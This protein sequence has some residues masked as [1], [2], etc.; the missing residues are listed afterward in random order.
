V[1]DAWIRLF[2]SESVAGCLSAD[3]V[4]PYTSLPLFIAT[5]R[6]I[7]ALAAH[8]GALDSRMAIKALC[9]DFYLAKGE[10]EQDYLLQCCRMYPERIIIGGPP[11]ILPEPATS[12]KKPWLVFFTEPYANLGWRVE[13]VYEDL[14]P[15]LCALARQCGLKLVFKLHPFESIKGHRN[16]LRKLLPQDQLTEILWVAGPPTTELWSK[17]QFGV[18]VEST[19][20]LECA[21][22]Q[23]PIFLCAWLQNVYGG[24]LQ[25]YAKFGVGHI[26]N[27]PDEM[28]HVPQLLANWKNSQSAAVNEIWRT[29]DPVKLRNLLNGTY[30]RGSAMPTQVG[31]SRPNF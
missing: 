21:M 14:L 9:A 31:M 27:S 24:Y 17:T 6:G 7:P 26:L 8:H 30:S 22:R 2:D 20:A 13:S 10:L 3:D 16:L 18:T 23:I 15:P 12:T 11:Q 25:Q 19:V 29:I 1:R 28:Q 5:Q 4:N